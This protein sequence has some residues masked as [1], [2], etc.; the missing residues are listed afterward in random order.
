M[1]GVAAQATLEPSLPLPCPQ[2]KQKPNEVPAPDSSPRKGCGSGVR[3]KSHLEP[4]DCQ[5]TC[6]KQSWNRVEGR[7][8]PGQPQVAQHRA[9]GN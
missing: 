9:E 6:W 1:L 3:V 5:G 2:P 7:E 4:S 8:A